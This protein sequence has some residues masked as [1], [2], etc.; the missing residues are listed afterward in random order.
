MLGL[1]TIL[2]AILILL[3]IAI[4]V[5]AIDVNPAPHASLGQG[6]AL[7]LSSMNQTVPMGMYAT[8]LMYYL[9]RVGYNVTYVTDGA[10]T[11]DFLL[12][13]LNNYDLIFWRTNTFNWAHL[14]Y[15][16][17]G[18][19]INPVT[20]QKY[21]SDFAA[22]WLNDRTGI[23]GISGDFVRAHFGP[24]TLTRVKLMVFISSYGN[25]V[26]PQFQTAGIQSVVFCNGQISLQ[27]GLI[28]DLSV[29]LMS[30]LTAGE[31]VYSAVYDTVSPFN[32]GQTP[33]DPIDTTYSPPF[34]Y[35]GDG[36]LT[37]V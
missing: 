24:N 2:I 25:S 26:A 37:I 31:N 18:E 10:V 16:Y 30:Y 20:E 32:Q 29:Q 13:H 17:V 3:T 6:Q 8:N 19:K 11:V 28:D 14:N 7:V 36:T 27:F 35:A 15:W 4:P 5:Q 23:F 9:K 22:G 21:A 1:K 34:W 33:K 12:N